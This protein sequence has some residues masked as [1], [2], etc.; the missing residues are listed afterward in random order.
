MEL[1]MCDKSSF[2]CLCGGARIFEM[3]LYQ[4]EKRLPEMTGGLG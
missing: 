3:C 1:V 2:I 4:G